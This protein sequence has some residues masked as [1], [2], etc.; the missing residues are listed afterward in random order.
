MAYGLHLLDTGDQTTFLAIALVAT[1]LGLVVPIL[2]DSGQMTT[3]FGQTV[4]GNASLAEFASI[5]FLSLFFSQ[6]GTKP[7]AELFLLVVFGL[8]VLLLGMALL[9]VGHWVSVSRTM[10]RL[11]NTSAQLSI[12]VAMVL[13]LVFV[14][15]SGDIGVE[16]VLGAFVAGALLRVVDPEARLT[17]EVFMGKVQ[18][19]G[20]GFL[21]PAFFVAT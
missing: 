19:I 3:T 5:V 6:D 16:T 10:I 2:Q 13:L 18:A 11:E 8:L 4:M 9:R 15:F 1:S 14:S 12:R 20:Y 21:V 7:S 17:H